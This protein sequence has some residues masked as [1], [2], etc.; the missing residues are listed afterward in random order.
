MVTFPDFRHL[1]AGTA[2]H[3]GRLVTHQPWRPHLRVVQGMQLRMADP[4][5]ELFHE[6]LPW[7]RISNSTSSTTSAFGAQRYTAACVFVARQL[8]PRRPAA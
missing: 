3:A 7:A 5:G 1:R 4:G 2:D 6:Q 8:T